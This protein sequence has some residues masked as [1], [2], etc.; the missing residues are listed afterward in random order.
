MACLAMVGNGTRLFITKAQQ[1]KEDESHFVRNQTKETEEV[2]EKQCED[3]ANLTQRPPT[4]A[5]L[6]CFLLGRSRCESPMSLGN[7]IV[8]HAQY[9]TA[10]GDGVGGAFN[11][12]SR[13]SGQRVL[14]IVGVWSLGTWGCRGPA[15]GLY[16]EQ[17]R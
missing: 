4:R 1:E 11:A 6:W 2:K 12:V 10:H 9:C 3:A 15:N 14:A 16:L 7:L 5:P 8:E 17:N 13:G